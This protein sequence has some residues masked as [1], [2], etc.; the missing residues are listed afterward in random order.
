MGTE[1]DR[2]GMEGVH[3]FFS[4]FLF[5]KRPGKLVNPRVRLICLLRA[6]QYL[7]QS[8]WNSFLDRVLVLRAVMC[9]EDVEISQ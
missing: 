1:G 6:V 8:L 5:R 4:F 9:E 2:R 3:V 7:N